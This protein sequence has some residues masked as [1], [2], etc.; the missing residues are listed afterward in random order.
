MQPLPNN[1]TGIQCPS[2]INSPLKGLSHKPTKSETQAPN[3]LDKDNVITWSYKK[4]NWVKTQENPSFVRLFQLQS[5][6]CR[7]GHHDTMSFCMK[8]AH[9]DRVCVSAKNGKTKVRGTS[10]CRSPLCLTCAPYQATKLSQ[11][12]EFVFKHAKRKGYKSFFVTAQHNKTTSIEKALAHTRRGRESIRNY[13]NNL[14]KR[15]GVDL[16]VYYVTED[17]LERDP[18]FNGREHI[19]R[20]HNH[21]HFCIIFKTSLP[22]S[23]ERDILLRVHK[24]WRAG[25]KKSG[26]YTLSGGKCFHVQTIDLANEGGVQ[27]S[28]YMSKLISSSY[29]DAR[30]CKSGKMKFELT[31]HHKKTGKGRSVIELLR[32]ISRYGRECDVRAYRYLVRAYKGKRRATKNESWKK[33]L[34]EQK[35]WEEARELDLSQHFI[36]GRYNEDL[37]EEMKRPQNE[38]TIEEFMGGFHPDESD[39]Q[40]LIPKVMWG[41]IVMSGAFYYLL[42]LVSKASI[43]IHR[44]LYD[45]FEQYCRENPYWSDH[46]FKKTPKRIHLDEQIAR[47]KDNIFI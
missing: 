22:I 2:I 27:L 34:K 4:A 10:P 23:R 43:G 9:A 18:Y 12:I 24:A 25:V 15:E 37:L 44:D 45:E 7:G 26:G 28:E 14:K 39:V 47:W 1:L 40:V 29:N 31:H 11:D 42:S 32:D 20:T 16:A 21:L 6:L 35:A 8:G 17:T 5:E 41:Y 13:V 46:N 3:D 33:M 36:E 30:S 38:I 19:T